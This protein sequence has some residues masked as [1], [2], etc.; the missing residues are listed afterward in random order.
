MNSK[1]LLTLLLAFCLVFSVLSP[2]AGAVGRTSGNSVTQQGTT[3][4]TGN[5]VNDLIVSAGKLLGLSLRDDQ[6]HVVNKDQ[7]NFV[8]GQW[9]ATSADGKSVVL[10]DAQLPEHIQALREMGKQISPE[11]VVYAFVTLEAA[12]TVEQYAS[13]HDV[14]ASVTAQM[15]SEQNALIGAIEQQVLG[16][17]NLK[18]VTSFTHLT[19]SVVIETEFAN[20]EAIAAVSGVKSVFLN[21]VYEPCKTTDT[22]YPSTSASTVM[23]DVA[24]VWQELGYTGAGMTIAILDTGVDVDHPSFLADPQGA[25]WNVAWLQEMLDTYDLRAE[26]LYNGTLTAEDLYYSAKVPFTFN[27]PMGNTSV[28]HND[29]L[30]DHGTHVAGIAAANKVE[31]TNVVGMAPD[32]QIIAMKVFNSNTGGSNMFDLI[33]ALEDCMILGVDVVNMS[34]GSPRGFSESAIEEIDSIFRRINESDI[35]VDVAAGNEGTT[36]YGSAYGPYLQTTTNLDNATISSPA[37]YANAMAI[38]SVDNNMIPSE[39]F[40]LADDTKV[41]FM[42]AIEVLYGYT[43]I[44]LMNLVSHGTVDY[45]VID[46]LGEAADFYDADGNSLVAGKVAV[47]RRGQISFYEKITNAEAAGALAV[48]IWNNET[49]NIFAFGMTTSTTDEAGNMILPG[50]PGALISLED[51]QVMADAENKTLTVSGEYGFRPDPDGGQMSSF[52]CW[53][54]SPDLRLLPDISGVGG[55]ILSCYDNGQYGVMSGTSMAC[56]QVAGVTA[57]VL[58]YLKDSFPNATEEETRILVDSLL[59]STAIPVVD[60]VFGVEASPRQQ[61]SGLVNAKNAITAGAYLSVEGNVRPKAEL[62]DSADGKF[63]FTFTVH[64]YS[65][66]A[67]TYTLSSSLLCEDFITDEDYP[68]VYFMAEHDRALD[69]SA[70]SFSENTVTVEAGATATVTVTIQLTEADKTWIDTYFPSGNYVEGFIY[71]TGEE[72]VTLSLPFLGFYGAWDAAPLFDTGYWYDN[73]FWA[74]M[75][76]EV[77]MKEVDANIYY[78][79]LWTMLGSTDWIL[80][81]NPYE[82]IQIDE[83]GDV[84]YSSDNNVLSPNGDGVLDGIVEVYLSLM[85]NAEEIT[86]LYT[87]EDGNVL[88]QEL[89]YKDAK[90]MYI[91]S[92]GQVV[93]FIYGWYYNDLYDFTD[94]N[95]NVLPDGTTVYLSISGVIDYE[96]ARENFMTTIPIHVDTSA[97]VLDVNNV[98]ESTDGDNNYVTLTFSEAHPAFAAMMNASGTQVYSRFDERSMVDNGDGTWSITMDVT[99]L[100]DR[101]MVVLGDYGCNEAYYEL[102]WSQT[103]TNNPAVDEDALY[104]YQVYNEYIYYYYGWDAMFGW[105][106]IGKDTGD[107]TM[108][109]SD[110][111]E[112]YAINAA[113]YVDGYV[114][115]VDAGG[116]FLYMQPGLWNRNQICNLGLNVVDMAF[117]DVN[118]VMYLVSSDKDNYSFCLYTVDLLT[119]EL[120][121]LRDYMDQYSMPW[122]M[123]FVDGELYCC[124][125]YSNGFYKVDFDNNYKLTAVTLE[126]GTAFQP[127]TSAGKKVS[128]YYAQSMTYSEKDGLIYW[129][130]YSYSGNC[131]FLAIDPATWTSTAYGFD[132]NQEYVG[133]L[134]L[135]EKDY[136]LPSS[137]AVTKMIMDED[138][139]IMSTGME[140]QLSVTLLPWNAPVTNDV[141]WTSQDE[142][143]ATVENGLVC[144]LGEGVVTITA[145]YGDLSVDCVVNIIDVQGSL[146]AYKFYDGNNNYGYWLDIDLKNVAEEGTVFSPVDFLAAD[147]NGHTGI[148]YGF[149]EAGQCYWFNPETGEYGAL[150]AADKTKVPADMA[151]DYSTGLMYAIVY[152]YNTYSTTLYALNMNTGALVEQAVVYDI[153]MTLACSLDG[154]LYG[155]NILGQLFELYVLEG[156]GAGG[157]GG[158][159]PWFDDGFNYPDTGAGVYHIEVNYLMQTDLTELN[160]VQTMCYDH[161]NDV[162]LWINPETSSVYWIDGLDTATPFAVALGD[163]SNTGLIQYTGAHVI[164]EEIPELPFFYVT[165]AS[166][167]DM[168]MLAGQAKPAAVNVLPLNASCYVTYYGGSSNENVA[169]YD[170]QTG[171]VVAV[172]PG[173]CQIQL[174][175]VDC[176][177]DYVDDGVTDPWFDV[178]FTVT[179]KEPTDNIIGYMMQDLGNMDGY[180]W[181]NIPD[182]NPTQYQGIQY[183]YWN[184]AYMTLYAAEYADGM[185]YA[186]GYDDSDW[187]ANFQFLT[188]D[189]KTWSVIS[190][191]DMG[192][193]F[194]FVYDMA[195]DYTTGTMYALA[196]PS[197]NTTDLYYV[198]L[199][200]GQLIECMATGADYMFLSLT[201]DANGTIY[202]MANS[203]EEMDWETWQTVLTN[204]QLY[205]LDPATGAIE[206][207]MD[208]GATS[209]KLNSMAYDYDTGYIYWHALDAA[210]KSGLYLIDLEEKA[211]YNLGCIGTAGAQLTGLMVLADNYPE[212]PDTLTNLKLTTSIAELGAGGTFALEMFMQPAT[213]SAELTWSSSDESVATVDANGVVTAVSAGTAVITLTATDA[214]GNV[215]T[216]SCT[217]LVYG[218]EDYFITYNVTDGGFAMISRPDSTV[219]TNFTEGESDAAVTA[220]AMINGIIYGYDAENNLFYTSAE[221]NFQRVY[222]GNAGIEVKEPYEK[223]TEYASGSATYGYDHYYT[224]A[225]D[226]RDMVY[227]A[228]NDRLLVLGCQVEKYVTYYWYESATYSDRYEYARGVNELLGGCKIYSVDMST[229][230]LEEL[231]VVGGEDSESGVSMLAITDDGQAYTYSY[232]MDYVMKLDLTTGEVTYLTTFQNQGVYGSNEGDLMAMTYDAGTNALYMLFTQNGKYYQMFKFNLTTQAIT[233]VDYVGDVRYANYQYTAD[234]FAG[235]VLN[236]A[237]VCENELVD[238]LDPTC[239]EDGY[240]VYECI[241]GKT[242]TEVIPA[243]GHSYE[244]VVTDPTCTEDGYTT[245]TCHCGDSYVD[246]YVDALG[247]SHVITD[248]QDATCTEDGFVTY[249]CHCGDTYTEVLPATGHSFVDGTC[250]HCGVVDPDNPPTGSAYAGSLA[251]LLSMAALGGAILVF[252]RKEF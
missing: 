49:T 169:Y 8:N 196:G 165:A 124:K 58:Q 221:R 2:A 45:V 156:E 151:Y 46:G 178:Y 215:R 63:S 212:I 24:A 36:S 42:H 173:T 239:T 190:A 117:D 136:T 143:L 39:F 101:F 162:L 149:T 4:S 74:A 20:L 229:G 246:D 171:K 141:V 104:A 144:A 184:G 199:A 185:I 17:E 23:T 78:H 82:G 158:I 177:E 92:Y 192:D 26:E 114:F 77:I 180:Y 68:D 240:D 59:M 85:R 130:Y 55:N 67:K 62:G 108:L 230:A 235:L 87:D 118:G 219:V 81:M 27:Y 66:A 207:F 111:Y 166:G 163:P 183:V 243:T 137:D 161:N 99:G 147:Y 154:Q 33:K 32:A 75:Y 131:D 225:F 93:P 1:R 195:F 203:K 73:G 198:N 91:S 47:V 25:S 213:V 9:I 125:Y 76:D 227:D 238:H 18:V 209:N 19:N 60:S 41:F 116:N 214:E 164:P 170:E 210:T 220:M 43:N 102:T 208:S 174:G 140:K 54:V 150:G 80:G 217:I 51:G 188:I 197:D 223:H 204:A 153:F 3:N 145:T 186:Y 189:T 69:N 176:G 48:L 237:H 252:K 249:T 241:C 211:S 90:T 119:G 247:H 138:V 206:W 105:A 28:I 244:A 10:T 202:A 181:I 40:A 123:T 231:C 242:T 94:E 172:G 70:V 129:A 245:Y 57:L 132:Y 103:G 11:E 232:Y 121:L 84:I 44:T 139:V 100:G 126:D 112:Y 65:D 135:E 127:L 52:S 96:G 79:T 31:G 89:L 98:V 224:P 53:G 64:N 155:I 120:T 236:Q 222:I 193:G 83:N 248:A 128:P 6:S 226:I 234:K 29:G 97:P 15:T 34:L 56:P 187:N 88:H 115:A 12:P 106:T 167:D 157:G 109:Q 200:N 86:F 7:L 251:I 5:W 61:G 228:A 110:A 250:E 216:A 50:I 21:P 168:V 233:L 113:E 16:G 122:A 71:L 218:A 22:M 72:E 30:G 191:V 133:L 95:G 175:V 205:T 160:Y 37:T 194:P 14:P 152:D 107:V 38:G 142:S 146:N 159:M 182:T 148:I 201:V 13:I 134:T 179:V 35:I